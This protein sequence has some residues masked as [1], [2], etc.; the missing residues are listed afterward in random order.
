V[1]EWTL[2]RLGRSHPEDACCTEVPKDTDA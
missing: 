1:A 2:E